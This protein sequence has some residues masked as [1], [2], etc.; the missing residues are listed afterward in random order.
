VPLGSDTWYILSFLLLHHLINWAQ[1]V[2]RMLPSGQVS[3]FVNILVAR[4]VIFPGVLSHNKMSLFFFFKEISLYTSQST[5]I[6]WT[7]RQDQKETAALLP[8]H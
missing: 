8:F 7:N 1:R 5:L 3:I 6:I 4:D 2:Q